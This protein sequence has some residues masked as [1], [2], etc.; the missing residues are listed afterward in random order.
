MELIVKR[1]TKTATTTTGEL[2]LNGK[3]ECYCLEPTDRGLKSTMSLSEIIAKKIPGKTAIPTGRYPMD[4]YFSPDH[5]CFVPRILNVPGFEDDEM[6]VGNFAKDTKACQ[7]LGTSVG[8]NEVLNS[9]EAVET[10][11]PKFFKAFDS[12]EHCWVTVED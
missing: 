5:N 8:T 10:F 4:K 9:K 11:Y 6:H 1:K 3:F 7:L 2:L 12:G